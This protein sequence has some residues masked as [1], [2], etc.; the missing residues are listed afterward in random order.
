VNGLN[1]VVL[2][3][4]LLEPEGPFAAYPWQSA[5]SVQEFIGGGLG[6]LNAPVRNPE[7]HC[8]RPST[9]WWCSAERLPFGVALR[10]SAGTLRFTWLRSPP[11]ALRDYLVAEVTGDA[12]DGLLSRR[13]ALRRLGLLGVSAAAAGTML[14]ACGDDETDPA[15]GAG[16]S[17][18][19]AGSS[20]PASSGA[21]ST[22]PVEAEMITFTGASGPLQAAFAPAEDPKGA[23]L[24]IHENRG[25][26]PHFFSVV[27]RLAG[28][29]YTALTV[30]LLSPEGGT[31]SLNDE[32]AASAGLAAAPLGRLLGDLRSGLDELER[33]A[34][35]TDLAAIGFCFGGGMVWNLLDTGEPRLAA[36][37]PFY[38]PAPPAPDFTGETAAVLAIYGE[39]DTGVNGTRDRAQ[40]ALVAAN[41]P[42]EVKTYAGAGHAFFN[43]TGPR[44]DAGAAAEAYTD[45]LAWLG[46]HL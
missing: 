19:A 4:A 29:G 20:E 13:E 31:A 33:R 23:V 24:V 36:A 39:Q 43:D 22:A 27:G 17:A 28:D 8:S 38:G 42:H 26:T 2:Q 45:V 3:L 10:G 35:D 16:G 15:P 14:A 37:V 25:L 34:P 21:A 5:R 9:S 7:G 32:G 41:L 30:D 40:A 11:M 44:Y 1:G 46:D 18:S 6:H 12:S